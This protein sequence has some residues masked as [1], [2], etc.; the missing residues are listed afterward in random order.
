MNIKQLQTYA[1]NYPAVPITR[2]FQLK[3]FDPIAITQALDHPESPCFLLTGKPKKDEDG[4]SFIGINPTKSFTYRNGKLKVTNR[5]GETFEK[6][7]ALKPVIEA[8]LRENRTP[9]IPNLPPFLGGLAGYFS[10]DYEKYATTAQLPTVQ[11][12]MGLNDADLLLVDEV[13]A[14][15]HT[16]KTVTLSKIVNA[17]QLTNLYHSVIADLTNLQNQLLAV[18]GEKLLPPFSMTPLQLQFSLQE[19]TEKVAQT[20]QHIVD[21]DI[22]QLILSNPQQA[23]MRGSLFAA[24]P[25]LFRESPSPYQFYFRHNDFETI[26]ASPETLITKRG[27]TLFTYPLAGTR[28]RGRDKAEDDQLASELQH[29]PK[30]LSEHNMLIDLGR[31]DLGAV[32]QFGSVQVTAY[33]RLLKFANVMHMGSTVESTVKKNT[34]AMD[35]INAVLPAGTL[36]GAPKIS[37]MQLIGQLENRKRGVYGGCLGY[38]GFDGDLDLCIG[39]RLAYRKG[40]TLVVH[41]GAGIVAD[42][43]AKYEYQEFN[44]KASAV[45]NALKET[46]TKGV[47][48]DALS[49]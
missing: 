36:S 2:Q 15:N 45:V 42:S 12:P 48:L 32:S 29:S 1:A 18:T 39:I 4:Y 40:K 25:T 13:I 17:N 47:I 19:F 26:G 37:A 27:Q 9:H 30:E 49:H 33:R 22:F 5:T 43:V 8:V 7:V 23:Q 38:L 14:Y 6:A 46:A 10:Y 3:S 21:G 16:T 11:D 34:S 24:A 41:S 31:N 20:K 44:N 35:I 28:R